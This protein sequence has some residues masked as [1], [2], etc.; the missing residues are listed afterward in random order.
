MIPWL[1]FA[2]AKSTS[3]LYLACLAIGSPSLSLFTLAWLWKTQKKYKINGVDII[4]EIVK[5]DTTTSN[6][7]IK[8]FYPKKLHDG[9]N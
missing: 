9:T 5:Q 7:N 3:K 1:I 4:N 2:G 6:N 8:K